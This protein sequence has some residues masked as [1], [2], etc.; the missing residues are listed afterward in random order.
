MTANIAKFRVRRALEHKVA[1]STYETFNT[2]NHI[3]EGEENQINNLMG[4]FLRHFTVDPVQLEK[5]I[6]LVRDS[7]KNEVTPFNI[8]QVK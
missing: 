7:L 2:G 1:N 5:R 6:V 3:L 4:E 8:A